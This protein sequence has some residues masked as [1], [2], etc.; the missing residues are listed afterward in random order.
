VFKQVPLLPP[1]SDEANAK[2]QEIIEYPD[3]Y[4]EPIATLLKTIY[5]GYL[6]EP[7]DSDKAEAQKSGNSLCFGEV[8][9]DGVAKLLDAD[10]LDAINARIMVDLG[11]GLGKLAMQAFVAYPNI[12][13]VVGLEYCGTRAKNGFAALRRLSKR[14]PPNVEWNIIEESNILTVVESLPQIS[15]LTSNSQPSTPRKVTKSEGGMGSSGCE[16]KRTNSVSPALAMSET[17]RL[18]FR[19]GD[20]FLYGTKNFAIHLFNS[21]LSLF[22]FFFS[23]LYIY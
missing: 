4:K 15:H 1:K 5:E 12:T 9:P 20:L 18:E 16:E 6:S 14:S 19:Q 21:N 7:D 10:H 3:P 22:F 2:K 23:F 17:R 13:K 11:M 8:L